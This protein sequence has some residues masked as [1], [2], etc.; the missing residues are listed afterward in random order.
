LTDFELKVDGLPAHRWVYASQWGLQLI[1]SGILLT[2]KN[3][4]LIVDFEIVADVGGGDDEE[5]LRKGLL[6]DV[7]RHHS[8]LGLEE[9]G[10]AV[11]S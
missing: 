4:V 2:D 8:S 6:V 9:D 5:Q 10:F 1:D 3:E 7:H 11:E